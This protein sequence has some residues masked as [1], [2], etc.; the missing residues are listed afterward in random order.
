MQ[1]IAF[2]DLVEQ[3]YLVECDWLGAH[4]DS[5]DLRIVEC[6]SQLP[7]Y[8]EPSAADGL[9]LTS[10]RPLFDE[11]HIAGATYVDLLHELS[12]RAQTDFMYAM[13]SAD[14]FAEV[15]SAVG[16]LT[17]P[18]YLRRFPPAVRR[19]RWTS[20]LCGRIV[21]TSCPYVAVLWPGTR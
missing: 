12:D 6:T 5:P 17:S 4:L 15:M 21:V 20:S 8:F 3:N 10:G 11:A 2:L 13:P 14:R 19:T 18:G 16:V 1:D 7:N 9:D